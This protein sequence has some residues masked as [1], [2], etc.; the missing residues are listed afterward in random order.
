MKEITHYFV[1]WYYGD[2]NKCYNWINLLQIEF[3][4]KIWEILFIKTIRKKHQDY[5]VTQTFN[6]TEAEEY[7]K[8]LTLIYSFVLVP[9]SF[10]WFFN[11]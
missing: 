6:Y 4:R 9:I 1:L 3:L 2:R 10:L 7:M 5:Y 11:P 8:S